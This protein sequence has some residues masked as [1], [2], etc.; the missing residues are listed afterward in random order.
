MI[1]GDDAG[2]TVDPTGLALELELQPISFIIHRAVPSALKYHL[3]TLLSYAE[4]VC[5]S[6]LEKYTCI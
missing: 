4:S 2:A 5:V 6:R 1:G 3:R